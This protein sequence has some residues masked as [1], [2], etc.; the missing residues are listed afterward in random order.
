MTTQ[1]KQPVT[2]GPSRGRKAAHT[3]RRETHSERLARLAD[4]ADGVTQ[5]DDLGRLSREELRKRLFG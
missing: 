4:E 5:G 1:L 2:P 3:A